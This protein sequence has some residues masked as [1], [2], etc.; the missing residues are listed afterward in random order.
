M[1]VRT[2]VTVM[3]VNHYDMEGNKGLSVRVVG[4][5]EETG[6]K[7]GVPVSEATVLNVSELGYL[8]THKKFLPARF[9]ADM[10]FTTKKL[11][12]GKEVPTM[13]LSNFEFL[14]AVEFTDVK[15]TVTK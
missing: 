7:F 11:G 9:N 13:A 5:Y 10:S 12:N 2:I 14:T 4:Y 6:N 1:N 3:Q 15:A 8:E